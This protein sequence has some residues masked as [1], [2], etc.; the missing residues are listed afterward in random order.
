MMPVHPLDLVPGGVGHDEIMASLGIGRD[1]LGNVIRE[2]SKN[3]TVARVE[4]QR[5]APA[6]LGTN[7]SDHTLP[8]MNHVMQRFDPVRFVC[9]AVAWNLNK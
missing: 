8:R 9:P 5:G 4:D 3:F 7:R 1:G 2:V 6:A